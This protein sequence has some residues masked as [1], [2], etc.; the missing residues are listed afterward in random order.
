MENNEF[1]QGWELFRDIFTGIAVAWYGFVKFIRSKNGSTLHDKAIDKCDDLKKSL[2]D[3]SNR[4]DTTL[5]SIKESIAEIKG[6]LR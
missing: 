3:H 1:N 5:S 4:V 6:R 2:D